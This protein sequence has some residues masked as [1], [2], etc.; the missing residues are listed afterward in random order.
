M[1]LLSTCCT[2]EGKWAWWKESK[3]SNS[4][5]IN[6]GIVNTINECSKVRQ[7]KFLAWLIVG[8]CS[9]VAGHPLPLP[10]VHFHGHRWKFL[11]YFWIYRW[12]IHFSCILVVWFNPHLLSFLRNSCFVLY[13][14]LFHMPWPGVNLL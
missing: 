14:W 11:K 10:E 6:Q 2:Q 3:Y 9:S 1:V 8:H 5:Q 12:F 13:V 7:G 4:E